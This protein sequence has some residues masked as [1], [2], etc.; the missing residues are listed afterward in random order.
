[1]AKTHGT[2][3]CTILYC[4]LINCRAVHNNDDVYMSEGRDDFP[5]FSGDYCLTSTNRGLSLIHI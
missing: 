4:N 2:P 5:D 1:M 3:F